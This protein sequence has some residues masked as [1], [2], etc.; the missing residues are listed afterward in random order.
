MTLRPETKFERSAIEKELIRLLR[1]T[2]NNPPQLVPETNIVAD[3]GLESVQII[4]YLCEVEDRFD[5]IINED[6]LADTQTIAEL[7]AVVEN[8]AKRE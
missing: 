6:A 3:L 5:L 8:L 4:E 1:D 2:L 7:A